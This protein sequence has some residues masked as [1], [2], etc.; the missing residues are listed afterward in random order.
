MLNVVNN[1]L[2][3]LIA[4]RQVVR[5]RGELQLGASGIVG[6][7]T[8]LVGLGALGPPRLLLLDL[9]AVSIWVAVI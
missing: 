3:L 5:N 2:T 6:V 4:T 1:R 7:F 9:E 8:L